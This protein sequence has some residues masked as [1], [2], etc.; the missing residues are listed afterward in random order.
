VSW[1]IS[2]DKGKPL[3]V[4]SGEGIKA[5]VAGILM[6]TGLATAM[7]ETYGRSALHAA[8][9]YTERQRLDWRTQPLEYA[10]TLADG[11]VLHVKSDD[12][13]EDPARRCNDLTS[14]GN[15]CGR[16]LNHRGVC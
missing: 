16:N 13:P 12:L 6:G 2:L 8:Q 10:Q 7:A 5:A 3:T 15:R 4:T 1:S 11:R 9:Q 14:E